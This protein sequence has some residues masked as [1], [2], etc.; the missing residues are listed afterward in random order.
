MSR[1]GYDDDNEGV[2]LWR[3]AVRAATKGQRGQKLLSE[4]AVAMDAMPE[5]K[6]ITNELA[7]DGEFCTL[8]VL[9]SARGVDMAKLD[10]T[11][12]DAVA[13]AFNI[14]PALAREIVY[15]NDEGAWDSETP[16]KRWQR[17]RGWVSQQLLTPYPA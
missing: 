13:V 10:P 3:G 9:G 8:G 7:A 6:L 5:K 17:M 2:N 4:L 14:A 16:E 11:D 15:M 1:S 12:A